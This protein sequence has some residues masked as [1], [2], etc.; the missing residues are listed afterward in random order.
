[1]PFGAYNGA[2]LRP[3]KPNSP[4]LIFGGVC[5]L[6]GLVFFLL[7]F[8]FY[9]DPDERDFTAT[10]VV[11]DER[12]IP[13]AGASVT[14]QPPSV[15]TT[16]NDAGHFQTRFMDSGGS[17]SDFALEVKKPGFKVTRVKLGRG[18]YAA[19]TI[20]LEAEGGHSLK[21]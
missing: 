2:P 21:P 11:V 17:I 19:L 15:T 7:L 5:C 12:G 14:L 20:R 9:G 16:T 18:E 13:V 4:I 6:F 3:Y 10:G 1:M 8:A